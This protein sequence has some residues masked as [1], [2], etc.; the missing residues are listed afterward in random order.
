MRLAGHTPSVR[1]SNS[2][3]DGPLGLSELRR[4]LRAACW[5]EGE[6]FEHEGAPP[7]GSICPE[8][9]LRAALCI[10][11]DVR[12]AE[13]GL[14]FYEVRIINQFDFINRVYYSQFTV[15]TAKRFQV[16][17]NAQRFVRIRS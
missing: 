10:S 12:G 13:G 3:A 6:C 2:N 7:N 5:S 4:D 1:G 8:T 11:P 16:G 17:S 14:Y 9:E 15:V